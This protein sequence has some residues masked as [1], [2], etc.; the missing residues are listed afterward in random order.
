VTTE[1][2]LDSLL[3]RIVKA[4]S[5]QPPIQSDK[6]EKKSYKMSSPFCLFIQ[7]A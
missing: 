5:N 2:P 1:I 3:E 7:I 6:E 4:I